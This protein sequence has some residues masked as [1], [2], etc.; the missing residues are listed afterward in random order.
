MNQETQKLS[1]LLNQ[2]TKLSAYLL[3][4]MLEEQKALEQGLIDE[5]QLI[6][7][8]K[9]NCLDQIEQVSRNRAQLLLTLSSATTT[10]ER[11]NNYI[12]GLPPSQRNSLDKSVTDLETELEKC[13]HQNSVN[14]MVITMSQRN[15][16]R[17]LNIIKG[18]EQQSVTYTQKGQTTSTGSQLG[19]LKV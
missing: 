1:N 7:S 18:N 17:N 13:R 11:L 16:Q 4:L 14:G 6:T 3:S 19:S 8:K 9:S 10:V 15:V 12:Y 5:L 2:E